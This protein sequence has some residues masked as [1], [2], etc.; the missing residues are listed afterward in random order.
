MA[1]RILDRIHTLTN[2]VSP[3]AASAPPDARSGM[4]RSEQ[5][6]SSGSNEKFVAEMAQADLRDAQAREDA[7]Y[8][9]WRA[10][11]DQMTAL[12][13]EIV[14][15]NLTSINYQVLIDLMTKAVGL[16]GEVSI[17][18]IKQCGL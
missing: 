11:E 10:K 17:S 13:V 12:L 15:L 1:Q 7:Y 8:A 2:K 9:E 4:T 6:S 3:L 16:L 5:A 18:C 14:S